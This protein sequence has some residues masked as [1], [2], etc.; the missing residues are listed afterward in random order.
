[1]GNLEH[2]DQLEMHIKDLGNEIESVKKASEY[3][4]LI[5]QFQAEMTE[6]SSDLNKTK[7]HLKVYQEIMEGKL[8]LFQ[9]TTRNIEAKQQS[10]EQ[11]Q[12]NIIASLTDYKQQQEKNEKEH[13]TS[14]KEINN[15]LNQNHDVLLGEFNRVKEEQ[16][17]LLKSIFK[18]TKIFISII[19]AS[20]VT[21]IGL[22]LYLFVK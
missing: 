9:T 13:K 1:M 22:L 12:L 7:N 19:A 6:T 21:A 5:E 17:S 14:F 4:K 10:L 18:S 2:I 3:L 15:L 16:E 11:S 20:S 8:E